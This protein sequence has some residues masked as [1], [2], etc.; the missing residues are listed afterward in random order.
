MNL[1]LPN[2]SRAKP[3]LREFL[4]HF[5]LITVL[6]VIIAVVV[7]YLMNVG[8]SFLENLVISM[9]IGWLAQTFIDGSR[10]LL[11]GVKQPPKLPYFCIWLIA[12]PC[13][14]RLGNA[15]AIRILDIPPENIAAARAQNATAFFVLTILVCVFISFLFW[16]RKRVE[17]LKAE[18]ETEKAR[19]LSPPMI[20][21]PCRHLNRL[22]SIMSSSRSTMRGC[23]KQ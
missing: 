19:G 13:A 5:A 21:S 3:A 23:P 12:I 9:C 4:V 22:R 1:A 18:A 15:I 20:N 10:L 6:N 7:T 14:Q 16:N 2:F 17:Q 11:W 8:R